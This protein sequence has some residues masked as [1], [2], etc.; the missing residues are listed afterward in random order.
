MGS[1]HAR[2]RSGIIGTTADGVPAPYHEG[3]GTAASESFPWAEMFAATPLALAIN[4]PGARYLLWATPAYAALHGYEPGEVIG[5]PVSDMYAPGARS[6][7]QGLLER[8]ADERAL[9]FRAMHL[10]KDGTTFPARIDARAMTDAGGVVRYWVV[11]VEDLTSAEAS[12]E[13]RARLAAIVESTQDAVVGTALDGVVTTWNPASERMFGYSAAEMVGQPVSLLMPPERLE[14]RLV[15]LRIARGERVEPYETVRVRKDGTRIDVLLSVSPVHDATGRVAGAAGIVRDISAQKEAEAAEHFLADASARLAQSLDA[16]TTV[17]ALAELAV[18]T[19]ADGCLVTMRDE[20]GERAGGCP[21]QHVA[22]ASRVPGRGQLVMEIERRFPLAVDSPSGYPRAIR[23]GEGELVPEGAFEDAVLPHVARSPEH[24]ALLRQLEMRSAIVVPLVARGRTLGAITLV[25]HGP[26]RRPPFTERDLRIGVELGRRAGIALDNARLLEAERRARHR[27]ERLQA[28]TA[29]LS[30]PVSKRAVAE[31]TIR[32]LT[33]ALHAFAGQVFELSADGTEWVEIGSS[34]YPDEILREFARFPVDVPYPVREVLRTR[35]PVFLNSMAEWLAAGYT[36]PRVFAPG[37]SDASWAAL[38]MLVEGR[39]IGTI[40]LI[41]PRAHCI[42]EPE[43]DLM[44][45]FAYQAALALERARLLASEREARGEAERANRAKSNFLATMSHELR[46]PLN[47]IAGYVQLMELGLRGPVTEQQHADLGRIRRSQQHLLSLI[48][49]VLSFA[50]IETGRAEYHIGEVDVAGLFEDVLAMAAPLA[51]RRGL[52]FEHEP[53]APGLVVRADADKL[54]Q[55]LINL[56][57]NAIK[58]TPEG[59]CVALSS[60][61]TDGEV[62]LV[63][64]DTGRGI[65]PEQQEA[66]FEPFVQVGRALN[67]SVE[68]TGL[69]LAISREYARAMGGDVTV[70]SAPDAGATFT[71]VLGRAEGGE[72]GKGAG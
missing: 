39:I 19:L 47:A 55:I 51:A 14:E 18:G 36:R 38:P 28:L 50:R 22:V 37:A 17:R 45:A 9:T 33:T 67:S 46:T 68:G 24:L 41:F 60:C 65:A 49:E 5:R 69:G 21:Y 70:S 1:D 40:T 34:Q 52:C 26:D 7:L 54:R 31:V 12:A 62:H 71:V 48:D 42:D 11:T 20:A 61:A 10:R 59:G 43:R 13:V 6:E 44:M 56:V 30:V 64:R 58:F 29:A 63:V 57:G 66:I 3:A 27:A 53:P 25:R 23:T 16:D 4:D 35:A 72:R 32:Q 15:L 8:T 2:E